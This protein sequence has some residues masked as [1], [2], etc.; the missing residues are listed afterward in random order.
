M[1]SLGGCVR[2]VTR[3]RAASGATRLRLPRPRRGR[4]LVLSWRAVRRASSSCPPSPSPVPP[5]APLGPLRA[6]RL[7]VSPTAF[8]PGGTRAGDRR[9]TG[10]GAR[11]AHRTHRPGHAAPGV[12]GAD[13]WH[14]RCRPGCCYVASACRVK[15]DGTCGSIGQAWAGLRVMPSRRPSV[16]WLPRE[17][18]PK[19]CLGHV[20]NG[21]AKT[22]RS[23]VVQSAQRPRALPRSVNSGGGARIGRSGASS[24]ALH[25]CAAQY[26]KRAGPASWGSAT[27]KALLVTRRGCRRWACRLSR[28]RAGAC[29]WGR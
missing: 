21:C 16:S 25:R 6:P 3:V 27:P 12:R 11:R 13:V 15:V 26:R 19:V 2:G 10:H 14:P 17:L 28:R 23:G 1:S 4:H 20:W 29:H 24:V 5:C 9:A 22:R 18:W 7:R 8:T